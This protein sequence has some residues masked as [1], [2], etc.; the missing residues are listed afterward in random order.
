MDIGWDGSRLLLN[1]SQNVRRTIGMGGTG[2][3][4]GSGSG[5]LSLHCGNVHLRLLQH[6][7]SPWGQR[8]RRH[9]VP[10]HTALRTGER[11]M[12]AIAR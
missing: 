12:L 5:G 7:L 3:Q 1:E 9:K 4:S 8:L 10:R 11:P 2:N 6:M